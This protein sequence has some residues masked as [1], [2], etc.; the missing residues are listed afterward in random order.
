MDLLREPLG[1]PYA[2]LDDDA[3]AADSAGAMGRRA[4]VWHC[5]LQL[6]LQ[7]IAVGLY[8][9]LLTLGVWGAFEQ[10]LSLRLGTAPY[11]HIVGWIFSIG[12]PGLFATGLP[13]M[14]DRESPLD[15][16]RCTV[17]YLAGTYLALPLLGLYLLVLYAY[18]GK[19]VLTG[20]APS[21]LLSPLALGAALI[22]LIALF[23]M[24]PLPRSDD[25]RGAVRRMPAFP[26]A[27]LPLL[28]M[29]AWALWVRIQNHGW[30]EVRY[31]RVVAVLGVLLCFGWAA[32]RRLRG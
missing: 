2:G 27:Y 22:G 23:L 11:M 16:Q 26:L 30:T 29:P 28:P 24:E 13:E 25:H 19:V 6:G 9:G 14:V 8:V 1:R 31:L 5:N 7:A 17:I 12:I 32:W 4:Y 20:E 10:L 3:L 18:G 15:E 21:N